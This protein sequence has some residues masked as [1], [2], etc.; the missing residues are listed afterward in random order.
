MTVRTFSLLVFAA[1]VL[2][3]AVAPEIEILGARPDLLVLAAVYGGLLV[4]SRAATIGGFLMGLVADTELPEYLGLNALA[5]AAI[6]YVSAGIW[7]HLVRTNVFVQCV[8]LFACSMLHDAVYYVVYYRNHLEMYG[9]FM[10][11]YGALGGLYTAL[12]GAA[13]FGLAKVK[14]W[15]T[16]AGDSG[17]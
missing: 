11:R 15:R 2:D 1:A 6:G 17:W 3:A 12:L 16:I 7:D 13:V 9:R 14:R 5:M 8:V 10:L 4:G